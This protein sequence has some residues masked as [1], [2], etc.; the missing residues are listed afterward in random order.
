MSVPDAGDGVA[1]ADAAVIVCH[2]EVVVVI[3]GL[4]ERHLDAAVVDVVDLLE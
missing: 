2:G 3:V 4:V 1:E